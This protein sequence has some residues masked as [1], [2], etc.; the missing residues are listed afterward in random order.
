MWQVIHGWAGLTILISCLVSILGIVLATIMILRMPEDYFLADK[1]SR[2]PS[3]AYQ[4]LL[5]KI[6]K[7]GVGA[8]M[9]ILGVA[10]IILPGPGILAILLGLSYMD[11]PGKHALLHLGLRLKSVRKSLNW[12]RRRFGHPMF[13]FPPQ[14]FAKNKNS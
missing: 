5:W 14:T 10:M 13:T 7:N 2:K 9:I 6:F 8:A 11:V 4:H 12:V 1:E 3:Q